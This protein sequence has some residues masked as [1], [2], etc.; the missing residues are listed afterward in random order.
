MF[1]LLVKSSLKHRALV[2]VIAFFMMAYGLMQ[3]QKLP[4]DVFPNLN[5]PVVTVLTEAGGMAPQEVEQ[6]VTFPLEN[7]LN[8]VTGVTRLRSTSGV[9]LSIIYIEFEWDTDI[10]RNR[11]LVSERLDLASEQLPSGI[12]SVMGPVSSI[13]GEVMLIALPIDDGSKVDPMLAREYAD[14]VLRPRL[15][16]IP[17]VS[18]VIP[19][20]GEVRQLRVA[21]NTKLMR[22]LGV[23]LAQ[24]NLALKD[25]SANFG[26]GFIDLNNQEY[27][28][29]HKGRTLDIAHL[30]NLAVGW[31]S[32]RPILLSQIADV[33]YSAAVK[34]GD[35]GFNSNP[36][37]VINIQKQPNAD[38]VRLTEQIELALKELN[39]NLPDAL[40]EPKVLFRQADFISAS[41]NNVTEALRDGAIMVTIILFL[42]LLSVKTTIISLFAI[43]LSLAVTVLIFQWLGQSINVMTLGGLA[44]AIGELVDDSVVDVENILRRLKQ[45]TQAK[46]PKPLFD[47][48]W[49]ASVEVRSGIVYATAIVILVFL[50]LFALPGIEGRVFSPLGIAYIVA[51]LGSLLV[52]MTVTPVLCYYLLPNAK[53]IHQNDSYLVTKLKNWQSLWINWAL[54]KSKT[55]IAAIGIRVRK[56]IAYHGFSLNINNDLSLYKGIVPCGIKDKDVTSLK[57]VG[58]L[59]HQKIEDVI[60]KNFLNTFH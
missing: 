2:L 44:I 24:L 17:G 9:G 28:I 23:N 26:G 58:V 29:R 8:G 13:M 19:I 37:V 33:S 54:P 35:G 16:A 10:Y 51:I 31:H 18:Q 56:W 3:G 32:E 49:Q 39:A 25:F 52:S 57:E 27:L 42:F 11:Q 15:L 40:T 53:V 50:P 47:V 4:V 14:F 48:I 43:P 21:P 12:T 34:R 1:N 59:N 60:I 36:A 7:L 45:N 5:K 30:Q 38:T 20:G 55:L 6:L 22:Q 41:I 46:Q